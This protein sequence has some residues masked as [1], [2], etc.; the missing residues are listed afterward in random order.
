MNY[1]QFGGDSQFCHDSAL[2]QGCSSWFI[3]YG[4]AV[5][6][7]FIFNELHTAKPASFIS[8]DYLAV[9]GLHFN[10]LL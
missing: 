6:N 1:I 9:E 10:F 5:C 3:K 7:S 8:E 4:L 2:E